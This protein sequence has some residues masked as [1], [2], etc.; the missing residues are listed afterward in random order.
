MQGNFGIEAGQIIAPGDPC[1]SLL[2]Y[3][4]ARLGPGRMPHV[5]SEVVDLRGL[6]LIERWIASLAPGPRPGP[7]DPLLASTV[8]ALAMMRS[9]DRGELSGEA[10]AQVIA[11]GVAHQDD[12]VRGLF[13]R[14][15]QREPQISVIDQPKLLLKMEGDVARG[16]QIFFEAPAAATCRTCHRINEIGGQLGPDLSHIG[17]K[18]TRSELL[19]HILEPSARVDEPYVLH[20]LQDSAGAQRTG[21]IVERSREHL[22]LQELTG[23]R[24]RIAADQVRSLVPQGQSTMP[25]MLLRSFTAQQAA[26]LLSFLASLK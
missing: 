18:Y 23:Q 11:R 3:R 17:R 21:F 7:P 24:T 16:R 1:R 22:I 2:L 5:G 13:E 15:A 8:G 19:E 10:R 9:I 6:E 14:F 12:A 25:S 4:M 26:D 20:L